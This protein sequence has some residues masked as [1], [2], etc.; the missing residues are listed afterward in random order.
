MVASCSM[1][2]TVKLWDLTTLGLRK[3]LLGHPKA[4]SQL[5]WHLGVKHMAYCPDQRLI[6]SGGFSYDLV[7]NNPYLSSPISRLRGHCSSIVGVEHITGTSQLVTADADGFCKLWDLRTFS[8]MESFTSNMAANRMRFKTRRKSTCSPATREPVITCMTVSPLSKRVFV[9]GRSV[10]SFEVLRDDCQDLT[11]ESAVLAVCFN[12]TNLTFVTA[13]AWSVKVWDALKGGLLCADARKQQSQQTAAAAA[14]SAAAA[15][16]ESVG[17]N[18]EMFSMCLGAKGRTIVTGDGLGHIK[19]V[20]NQ[21]NYTELKNYT[22]AECKGKAHEGNVRA[23]ILAEEHSLLVSASSD[24]SISIHD[25]SKRDGGALLRR[26]TNASWSEI[27]VLRYSSHLGLIASGNTDGSIQL[28]NFEQARHEGCCEELHQY[29]VTCL[30]FLDPFPI[31]LSAD[32]AGYLALWAVPPARVGLRYKRIFTWINKQPVSDRMYGGGG[33]ADGETPVAVTALECQVEK[34]SASIAASTVTDLETLSSVHDDGRHEESTVEM[35]V[36]DEDEDDVDVEP[37]DADEADGEVDAARTDPPA[38]AAASHTRAAREL[39]SGREDGVQS[40]RHGAGD[41]AAT[42]LEHA[43]PKTSAEA[44]RT[45]AVPEGGGGGEDAAGILPHDADTTA[46]WDASAASSNPSGGSGSNDRSFQE[47]LAATLRKYRGERRRHPPS[48]AQ[49][50]GDSQEQHQRRV[51][52][53]TEMLSYTVY[54]ADE[55]GMVTT[56]DLKEVIIGLIHMYGGHEWAG[57]GVGVVQSPAVYSNAFLIARQ[58][59]GNALREA[60]YHLDAKASLDWVADTDILG[61]HRIGSWEA[62]SEPIIS[63]SMVSDPPTVITSAMDRLV[64]LWSPLGDLQG[65]LRQKNDP[66]T[67]WIFRVNRRAQEDHKIR[68]AER[69][70]MEATSI[71]RTTRPVA[72]TA[73]NEEGDSNE[74]SLLPSCRSHK[75]CI[76]TIDTAIN[77]FGNAPS[78]SDKIPPLR[79]ENRHNAVRDDDRDG[80]DSAEGGSDDGGVSGHEMLVDVSRRPARAHR[81]YAEEELDRYCE[82]S[83]SSTAT[84]V[85]PLQFVSTGL[86][87]SGDGGN[88]SGRGLRRTPRR[89]PVR[90][91]TSGKGVTRGRIVGGFGASRRGSASPR[92]VRGQLV[93]RQSLSAR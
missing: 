18:G 44:G 91:D 3:T 57:H 52:W 9:G 45:P 82:S 35:S 10:D 14:T 66:D 88:A 48:I 81:K 19:V 1:D 65:V 76:N 39:E 37:N 36:Q 6:V 92:A 56:W 29:P 32:A 5:T 17:R 70:I 90:P 85:G 49:S 59:A 64:K 7:V 28:W 87:A 68:A 69:V 33:Q 71:P 31:L 74:Q 46:A 60:R 34:I 12:T 41:A 86:L 83:I 79:L 26:I 55:F 23:L 25:E 62:H 47:R 24:R 13:S 77:A 51:F 11:D 61:L 73:N 38:A 16:V 67:P 40:R 2:H 78:N 80:S 30:A 72:G 20:Y 27:T 50:R 15:A 89:V 8:C 21:A 75:G 63:M 58:D 84:K 93:V 4:S 43:N 22:Y 42:P 53:N 54:T